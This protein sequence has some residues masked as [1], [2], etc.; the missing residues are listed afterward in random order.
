MHGLLFRSRPCIRLIPR[1]NLSMMKFVRMAVIAIF[2][3]GCGIAP[4]T[5]ASPTLPR[6]DHTK[7]PIP[8]DTLL[9]TL[10]PIPSPIPPPRNFTEDFNSSP[11][12]WSAFGTLGENIEPAL[13]D[14][15]GLQVR[16][17]NPYSW[18]YQLFDLYDY[19]DVRVDAYFEPR[20]TEPSSTGVVCRF[21]KEMGWY[22]F[23]IS[24]QGIYSVLLGKWLNEDL[25]QYTP[26]VYDESEYIKP[27]AQ[28]Y[29]IGLGCLA[30]ELWL[31]INGK[32][33]RKV[34]VKRQGLRAGKIG[35][36]VAS[37]QNAPVLSIVDW[38]KAT[39]P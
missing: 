8:I 38:F 32:L 9:A 4:D 35:L 20:G 34:N 5:N 1:Y 23:T 7:T 31:Y 16:L 11:A 27:E 3:V 26:I 12:Y 25:A 15:N 18:S 39:T 19:Q 28:G 33:I 17:V 30:D 13:I 24:R 21:S 2:L 29:E 22:E 10:T 36:T 6:G 14:E 37:F